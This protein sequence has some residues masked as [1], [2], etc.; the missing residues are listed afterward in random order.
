MIRVSRIFFQLRF[1]PFNYL[2]RHP[3][4]KKIRRAKVI[5]WFVRC[6]EDFE[7][8]HEVLYHAVKLFDLFMCV[9]RDMDQFDYIG[10]A[11][12]IIAAKLDVLLRLI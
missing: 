9:S 10:A 12:M 6:Q 1:R 2:S 8:N 3:A 11:S 4:L 7:V 5:D